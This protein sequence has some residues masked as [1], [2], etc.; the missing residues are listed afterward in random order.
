[1]CMLQETPWGEGIVRQNLS[2][3]FMAPSAQLLRKIFF[4]VDPL[5]P[6]QY[7]E[8]SSH[9][10]HIY[11]FYWLICTPHQCIPHNVASYNNLKC[12]TPTDS[13]M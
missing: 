7:W 11:S 5:S 3:T 6:Q 2:H 1:V 12:L 9:G 8:P 4:L 13:H 10:G